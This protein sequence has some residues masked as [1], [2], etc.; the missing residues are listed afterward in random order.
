MEHLWALSK[1]REGGNGAHTDAESLLRPQI[2]AIEENIKNVEFSYM[3]A[4]YDYRQ[5][6]PS[7]EISGT[8]PIMRTRALT[9]SARINEVVADALKLPRCPRVHQ[10]FHACNVHLMSSTCSNKIPMQGFPNWTRPHT[11]T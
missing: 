9:E 2:K 5:R 11:C 10:T 3:S 8:I 6:E 4:G 7:K 1:A